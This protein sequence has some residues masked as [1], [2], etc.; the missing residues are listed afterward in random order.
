MEFFMANS[1]NL[2]TD[3]QEVNNITA[4]HIFHHFS[5][6]LQRLNVTARR[7]PRSACREEFQRILRLSSDGKD[8]MTRLRHVTQR[9]GRNSGAVVAQLR[10]ITGINNDVCHLSY[11]SYI[12]IYNCERP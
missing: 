5:M 9:W 6:A 8:A 12:P 11:N 1:T 2:S 3:P 7:M 4:N 10:V